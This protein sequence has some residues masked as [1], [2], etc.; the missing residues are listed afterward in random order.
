M[1]KY[2]RNPAIISRI[3]DNELV[4]LN[5]NTGDYYGLNEIGSAIWELING[6]NGF[7]EIIDNLLEDYDVE[8]SVLEADAAEFIEGLIER[9]IISQGLD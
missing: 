4:L 7:K 2:I 8:R 5:A 6:S 3:I 9:K 1:E